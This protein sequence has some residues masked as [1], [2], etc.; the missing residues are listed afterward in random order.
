MERKDFEKA[1]PALSD[2]MATGET[3]TYRIAG[4]RQEMNESR[5]PGEKETYLPDVVDYIRRCDTVSQAVEIIE[6][7]L[8]RG[9]LTKSQASSIKRQLKSEGLRS[10]GAKKERDYYLHHG[11]G[12]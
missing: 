8:K 12:E 6:Y 3:K 9:E 5:S 1:F 2:E 10:F 11:I 4:V 7:L